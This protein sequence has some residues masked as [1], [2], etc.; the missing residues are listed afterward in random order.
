MGSNTTPLPAGTTLEG[1]G[2][3]GKP[4]LLANIARF[5]PV[6]SARRLE[7]D[8][9]DTGAIPLAQSEYRVLFDLGAVVLS[10][11][12][13]GKSAVVLLTLDT[14]PITVPIEVVGVAEEQNVRIHFG[15]DGKV[16][17]AAIVI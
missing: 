4:A 8:D 14:E 9:F 12:D 13:D 5:T 2:L 11:A 6:P 10:V 15:E 1:S 3:I 17:L 16:A 7:A